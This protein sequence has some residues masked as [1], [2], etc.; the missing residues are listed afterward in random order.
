MEE[1]AELRGRGCED[2]VISGL[3]KLIC[4][5]CDH[6]TIQWTARSS[7]VRPRTM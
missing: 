6:R 1:V 5:D 3:P 4:T 2:R 7:T